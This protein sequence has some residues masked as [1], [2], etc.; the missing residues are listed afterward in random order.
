MSIGSEIMEEAY[1]KK[2]L[3]FLRLLEAMNKDLDR[4]KIII[5]YQKHFKGYG[6]YGQE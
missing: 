3:E 4:D 5:E 2:V 1:D 6:F